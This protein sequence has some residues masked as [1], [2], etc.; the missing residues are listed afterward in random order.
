M[1]EINGTDTRPITVI[2]DYSFSIED[3]SEFNTYLE[4]G[5]VEVAKVPF[6]INFN[7]FIFFDYILSL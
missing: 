7:R 1:I 6:R 2:D 3:T 4:G 5:F